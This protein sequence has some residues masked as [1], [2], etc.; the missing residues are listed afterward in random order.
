MS[1]L[2]FKRSHLLYQKNSPWWYIELKV[3]HEMYMNIYLKNP[4]YIV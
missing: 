4:N 3:N 1:L 2:L